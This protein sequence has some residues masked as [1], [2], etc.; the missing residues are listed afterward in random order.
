MSNTAN[1]V[2]NA[3]GEIIADVLELIGNSAS[4]GLQWAAEQLPA[5][6][7]VFRWIGAVLSSLTD[8]LSTIAKAIIAILAG[9]IGGLGVIGIGLVQRD[10]PTMRRGS[11]SMLNGVTGSVALVAGKAV[12]VV[13]TTALTQSYAR[14]LT[15]EEKALVRRVFGQSL[16]LQNIR[17][18]SGRS[19]VF[20][21]NARPFV[22]GNT[23][24]FKHHDTDREPHLFIHECVHIWQ[25]QHQGAS[26]IGGALGAQ[27]FLQD[28][29]D[30]EEE[31]RRGK[32]DW[33][34]FNREA[35]GEFFLDLWR[36]GSLEVNSEVFQGDGQF[37]LADGVER[38]GRF[39][40][41]DGRCSS[42]SS[43]AYSDI[44]HAAVNT[45][46][47]TPNFRLSTLLRGR[48]LAPEQ[49]RT[50]Q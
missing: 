48:E 5:G 34:Q 4:D 37:F 14:K 26:Y 8:F 45:V 1:Q 41:R 42:E 21:R 7:S 50:P 46:R 43:D 22:L 36:C 9:L 33:T 31:I 13:Q 18:V 12:S 44:A 23:I 49:K 24:Y 19:G 47:G 6:G 11:Q 10:G 20:G 40:F 38:T 28:A 35:Q 30:W 16:A 2:I 29:Y 27:Y 39:Y 32:Q 3:I 15:D 25:Y 17:I